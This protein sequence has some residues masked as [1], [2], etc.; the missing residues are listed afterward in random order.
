MTEQEWKECRDP[1]TL[2]EFVLN[3]SMP[4]Q[5]TLIL[6]SCAIYRSVEQAQ[7][8]VSV[9]GEPPFSIEAASQQE[10]GRCESSVD[11]AEQEYLAPFILSYFTGAISV[12]AMGE[13]TPNQLTDSLL[14]AVRNAYRFRIQRR[15][16]PP[17][18]LIAAVH[19]DVVRHI[20][21]NP[22]REYPPSWPS[23]AVQLAQA[24]E[25]GQDCAFALH[26]ALL[27]SG[28]AELA[29]HFREE[30]WHPKGCFALDLILGKT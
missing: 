2:I 6:L 19:A 1:L 25:Q 21:G 23:A 8:S 24:F 29:E 18:E 3:K 11:R 17:D 7:S 13:F 30:K 5:R 22:F 16:R 14:E 26:D 15:D 27:E 9:S 10:L 28:H 12:H 4:S 20:I